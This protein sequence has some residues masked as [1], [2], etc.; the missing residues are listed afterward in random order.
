MREDSKSIKGE[1]MVKQVIA[2]RK[3]LEMPPGK[4]AAQV[5]HASMMVCLN[6]NADSWVLRDS[7]YIQEWLHDDYRKVVVY[8][9]SEQ[10]LLNL[11]DKLNANDI[12][13]F[14][15]QDK[16]YTYFDKPTYT[17]LGIEPLPEE[18]IDK[19]TKRLRLL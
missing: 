16:G 14:L 10:Q 5:A 15:V 11:K 1:R 7:K 9:K 13:C 19:Y 12:K 3:D 2:V 18:I 4:L 17:A 6:L 8:V